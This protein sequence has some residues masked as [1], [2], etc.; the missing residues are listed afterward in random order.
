MKKIL[1]A[2]LLNFVFCA[3]AQA[4]SYYFKSCKLTD[5]LVADYLINF[6]KNTITVNLEAADGTFQQFT[7]EI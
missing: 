6:D 1:I 3:T 7:D 5:V 2:I 4:E